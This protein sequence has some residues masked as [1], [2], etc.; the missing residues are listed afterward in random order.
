MR[1]KKHSDSLNTGAGALIEPDDESDELDEELELP[2]L[3]LLDEEG[4]LTGGLA[5]AFFGGSSISTDF[6]VRIFLRVG[7][8]GGDGSLA[9]DGF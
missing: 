4:L 5:S 2:L 3:L 8:D 6:W 1:M 7:V 9:E